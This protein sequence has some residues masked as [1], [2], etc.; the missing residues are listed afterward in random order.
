MSRVTTAGARSSS[1]A[2]WA[3]LPSSMT[4]A[5]TRIARNWSMVESAEG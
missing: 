2:A 4:R 1:R 3:K 5:K